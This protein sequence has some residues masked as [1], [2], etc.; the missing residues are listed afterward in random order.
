MERVNT[1]QGKE[2]DIDKEQAP[3]HHITIITT[4]TTP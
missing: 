3:P 4:T 2:E 1:E